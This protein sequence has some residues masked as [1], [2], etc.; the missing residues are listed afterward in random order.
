MEMF[1]IVFLLTCFCLFHFVLCV[2]I[3]HGDFNPP[4][5]NK[6]FS[7]KNLQ[8]LTFSATKNMLS[9]PRNDIR[10]F[11]QR[12]FHQWKQLITVVKSVASC[13]C[14]FLLTNQF[15][16]LAVEPGTNPRGIFFQKLDN[17][18]WR[19]KPFSTLRGPFVQNTK[20]VSS[21]LLTVEW[22]CQFVRLKIN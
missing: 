17:G 13:P 15:L 20:W 22:T 5:K 14:A 3:L 10:C 19:K 1:S 6:S 12:L 8:I 21:S 4:A 2:V 18:L 9:M 11:E 7:T 16:M